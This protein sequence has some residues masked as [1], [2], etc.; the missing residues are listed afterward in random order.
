M[1]IVVARTAGFC[2]GVR[3]AVDL[4]LEAAESV[5]GELVTIG[6]LIHNRQVVEMLDRNG[7]RVVEDV[8]DVAGGGTVVVRAHGIAPSMRRAIEE[9]GLACLD[10][11]CPLVVRIQ[12]ILQRYADQGYTGVI[13]GDK[14]HAEVTG[15]LAHTSGRGVVVESANDLDAVPADRPLCVVAQSTQNREV[16]EA[17]VAKLRARGGA[18]TPARMRV[19]DTV[20]DATVERQDE[21]RRLARR[22]DAVVVVGGA[23]SANTQR[24]AS[25]ARE[26]GVA[27]YLI[28]DADELVPDEIAR[29]ETVGVTA[30]ASTPNW[31]IET[32]IARL[33]DIGRATKP[34]SER[35]LAALADFFVKSDLHVGVGA[36]LLCFACIV[37]ENP[38]R[39][40][41]PPMLL[42]IT[43]AACYV[44]AQHILNH[45][46]DREYSLYK[47]SY[48]LGFLEQHRWVLIP[49][50]ALAAVAAVALAATLGWVPFAIVCFATVMGL[51]YNLPILPFARLR[52][53]RSIPASKNIGMAGAWC[54]ITVI[55]PLFEEPTRLT[56][57]LLLGVGVVFLFAFTMVFARSTILDMRDIQGDLMVGNETIP[58]IIGRRGTKLLLYGLLAVCAAGLVLGAAAGWT[59]A[60][61]LWL[62]VAPAYALLCIVLY[63]RG[64]LAAGLTTEV[65]TDAGFYVAGL[66]ALAYWFAG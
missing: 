50:G 25:I 9:A 17:V 44:F 20:C 51:I 38:V 64:V 22:C 18:Q 46:T 57:P 15:L 12:R 16:F 56:G 37:L 62:L 29:H 39:A 34:W 66:V 1:K 43:I 31:L 11:T 30:G 41:T 61:G 3:R 63:N 27:T 58:I 55:L 45:F 4:V 21:V 40:A 59:S 23:H 53:L 13:V 24:L 26:L 42:P 54:V 7:V 19:F 14:G 65:V 5:P 52:R 32:V 35:A 6:P 8:R 36:G 33:R 28:E 47:E 48:K 60:L 2:M 49:L 10:A